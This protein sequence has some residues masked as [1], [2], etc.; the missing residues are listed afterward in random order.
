MERINIKS[1]K[2]EN[3][4][5]KFTVKL[6]QYQLN[7][8]LFKYNQKYVFNEYISNLINELKT[9]VIESQPYQE[10]DKEVEELL[11]KTRDIINQLRG[12]KTPTDKQELNTAIDNTLRYILYNYT[13]KKADMS[14]YEEIEVLN[15]VKLIRQIIQTNNLDI[16]PRIQNSYKLI[17]QLK[18]NI[19]NKL[20]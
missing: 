6:L 3:V 14:L 8:I 11:L 7:N 18:E 20:N 17:A 19:I 12:I 4:K 15:E 9:T 10:K 2:L 13:K 16:T 1:I 5:V